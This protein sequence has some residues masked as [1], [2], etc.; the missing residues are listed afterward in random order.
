MQVSVSDAAGNSS[1]LTSNITV[2][3]TPP[4]LTTGNVTTDN[5]LNSS[6]VQSSQLLTGTASPSSAGQTVTATLNGKTYSSTVGSDG[7]WSI[8][9]PSADSEQSVRWQLQYCDPSDRCRR[10]YHDDNADRYRRC[11]PAQRTGRHDWDF[12]RQ[13]HY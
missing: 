8:T 5:I 9:I 7:I 12:R 13:Q 10:Q 3:R 4:T 1:T 11:Q 6:E 2:A